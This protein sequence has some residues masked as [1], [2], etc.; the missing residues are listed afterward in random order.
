M[1]GATAWLLSVGMMMMAFLLI[2]VSP[3]VA[4]AD[5]PVGGGACTTARDC[6][7]A[8]ECKNAKCV[9]D[10]GWAVS[11]W[12]AT[13][14][15]SLPSL[16]CPRDRFVWPRRGHYARSL[17]SSRFLRSP[18]HG[19]LSTRRGHRGVPRPSRLLTENST[20]ANYI[21]CHLAWCHSASLMDRDTRRMG[22]GMV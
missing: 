18:P 5:L 19:I 21:Q 2:T 1:N 11:L 17:T 7:L 9:C 6:Q 10:P 12:G 4:T 14:L 13:F 16:T 15:S 8:G 20:C 22:A 3:N